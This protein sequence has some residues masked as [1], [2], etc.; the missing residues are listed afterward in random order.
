SLATAVVQLFTT[1][2]PAHSEWKKRETGVLCLI[3]DNAKRS[4]FFRIFCLYRK[5]LIWEHEVYTQIEYKSPRTFLHTFE[6]E[7][8][9]DYY[10]RYSSR[11]SNRGKTSE[12]H[13]T[14][15]TTRS[16][17]APTRSSSCGRSRKPTLAC[18]MASS[19]YRTSAG[20]RRKVTQ[21]Q[22]ALEELQQEAQVAQDHE[23]RHRHAAGLQAHNARRLGRA[24]SSNKKLKLRK[25]TKADIGMPQ[26]FKHISHVGWDAQKAGVSET[27]LQDQDTREF[28]YGFIETHGGLD[29]V[30]E[31]LD[32]AKPSKVNIATVSKITIA[33]LQST[34]HNSN[35]T[36]GN[37]DF[38]LKRVEASSEPPPVVEDSRSNLLS[39][40]RKGISLK[41]T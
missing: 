35:P 4:Y 10:G 19:T 41:K 28:I 2:G 29:A 39:D 15:T 18:R 26:D 3:K 8:K 25:I 11:R 40:I 9:R 31:D 21:L 38:K 1:E 7:M 13:P 20:T 34:T 23:S 22:H 37:L 17:R 14:A 5:H 27:Q 12:K 33:R 32:Q 36:I 30:K 24:E 6:A 16:R